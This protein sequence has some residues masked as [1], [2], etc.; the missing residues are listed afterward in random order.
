MNIENWYSY[1]IVFPSDLPPTVIE[2]ELDA[3][4]KSV[5]EPSLGVAKVTLET[6]RTIESPQDPYK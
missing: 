6:Q 1:K 4:L 2:Q 3:F 5:H